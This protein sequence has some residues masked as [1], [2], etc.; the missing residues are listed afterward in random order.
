MNRLGLLSLVLLLGACKQSLPPQAFLKAYSEQA[1]VSTIHGDYRITLLQ[2]SPDYLTAGEMDSADGEKEL[3]SLHEG[4]QN[5]I[6]ISLKISCAKPTGGPEDI[7]KDFLNGALINGQEAFS[8]RLQFLESGMGALFRLELEDGRLIPLKTYRFNRGY[9]LGGGHSF[10]LL[11][12][13]QF[14]GHPIRAERGSL[15]LQEFGLSTGTLKIQVKKA[16]NIA[17]KA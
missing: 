15:V 3:K 6:Y 16:P 9:A 1:T 10:V 5:A 8:Q 13:N 17:L 2:M 11:F 14:D 7:R 12:P 4:Y